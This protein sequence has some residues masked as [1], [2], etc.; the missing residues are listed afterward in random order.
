MEH[1]VG[2]ANGGQHGVRVANVGPVPL[3]L[4]TYFVEVGFVTG[5]QIVDDAHLAVARGRAK[6]G[7]ARSR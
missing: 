7:P 6:R 5:Q 1:D 2:A 3:N 4:R